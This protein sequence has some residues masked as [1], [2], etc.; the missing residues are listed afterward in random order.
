MA[1]K[2]QLAACTTIICV[3]A[4]AHG[5]SVDWA[6]PQFGLW[7]NA[8]N[9]A[10]A[11]IPGMSDTIFLGHLTPYTVFLQGDFNVSSLTIS[12]PEARLDILSDSS[13]T[14]AGD[15]VNQGLIRINPKGLL[16]PSGIRVTENA[17]LSGNGSLLLHEASPELFSVQVDD[18]VWLK[19]A[20]GHTVVGHGILQ[21]H[22]INE[23]QIVPGGGG[24]ELDF[25][26][27]LIANMSTMTALSQSS[28][29][30]KDSD[31][32]Q[33]EKGVIEA[34]GPGA[35]IVL[36]GAQITGGALGTSVGGIVEVLGND[37]Y[38]NDAYITGDIGISMPSLGSAV[39]F[40]NTQFN[41]SN[42]RIVKTFFDGNSTR[43]YGGSTLTGNGSIRL[44]AT[45]NIYPALI[46][47]SSATIDGN[48]LVNGYGQLIGS[49]N[50]R[51]GVIAGDPG[52]EL[53]L[54]SEIQSESSFEARNGSQ[55]TLIGNLTQL[56]GSSLMSTGEG[57]VLWLEG[58]VEGGEIVTKNGGRVMGAGRMNLFNVELNANID[59]LGRIGLRGST[60]N[61]GE[62][63]GG[64]LGFGDIVLGGAG[65]Y[66]LRGT[67]HGGLGSDV[68][69][70]THS[71][72][73]RIDGRGDIWANFTNYGFVSS[74]HDSGWMI[75]RDGNIYN[76]GVIEAVG[77]GTLEMRE[78][79][80]QSEEGV[81]RIQGVGSTLQVLGLS[82]VGGTIQSSEGGE[83]HIMSW[84]EFSHTH[85]NA[86]IKVDKYSIIRIGEGVL[87][88]GVIEIEESSPIPQVGAVVLETGDLSEGACVFRLTD[89]E[90]NAAIAISS[91]VEQIHFGAGHRVEGVGRILK[92]VL[93]DGVL[94][95]GVPVGEFSI[96]FPFEFTELGM[97]EI[98]IAT[99]TNDSI[100]TA[101]HFKLGGT[102][103][104]KFVD[105]FAPSSYWVRTIVDAT[106]VIGEFNVIQ[107]PPAPFGL[108][109]RT[110]NTGTQLLVG[111]TCLAD[112]NL[113]GTLDFFD[114][115]AMLELFAS[116]NPT[117]D[118]TKDGIFD[119]FDIAEFLEAF[120]VGC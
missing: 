105:G 120:G 97:L 102:L 101:S 52:R 36:D 13:I 81:I 70:F 80:E 26:S 108:V 49:F 79:V 62:V 48:Y 82:F 90:G 69:N 29:R 5:Q 44:E 106:E 12:N 14:L 89:P 21:G 57:S 72:G 37:N 93:M 56:E 4:L 83:I 34:A 119:F 112:I 42:I 71:K 98:D 41:N 15:I 99:N 87:L 60:I 84:V 94:A 51:G 3:T 45:T 11:R 38:V 40:N 64:I 92:D 47:E 8:D 31:I 61:N 27:S 68:M 117:V 24:A 17:T 115:A 65:I 86:H 96:E 28:L 39:R 77:G 100:S 73:H 95:P 104:I 7:G 53:L 50:N 25:K 91:G 33:G 23:G 55:L 30:F 43:L 63:T 20:L 35:R 107:S 18:G 113:D 114:V 1:S 59:N 103:D 10:P 19:N 116:N 78:P 46:I 22:F 110:Y 9:W 32:E 66:H 67:C 88:E 75:F 6:S 118:F 109:T 85:L 2:I 58:T 76:E 54:Y 74:N 16:A 111:Q